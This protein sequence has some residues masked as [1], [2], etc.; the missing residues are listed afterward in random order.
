MPIFTVHAERAPDEISNVPHGAEQSAAPF[1]SSRVSTRAAGDEFVVHDDAGDSDN[2][3]ISRLATVVD[4]DAVIVPAPTMEQLASPRRSRSATSKVGAGAPPYGRSIG[5]RRTI[6]P[7]LLTLGVLL[8][9]LGGGWFVLPPES[10]FKPVGST[11]P[12][13]L[14][15][16]GPLMLLMAAFNMMHVRSVMQSRRSVSVAVTARKPRSGRRT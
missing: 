15:A 8:P 7:V 10:T 4:D 3:T 5:V 1:S 13:V 12:I 11:L 16:L 6:I 14:L 2:V 9:A